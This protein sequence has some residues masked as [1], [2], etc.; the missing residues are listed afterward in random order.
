MGVWYVA[1]RE[2]IQLLRDRR[3]ILVFVSVPVVLVLLFG[4][5]LSFDVRH[6]STVVLDEDRTP[7]S[8]LL[9]ERF[10]QTGRFDLVGYVSSERELRRTLDYGRA[11]VG[12]RIPPRF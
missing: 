1:R 6:L 10:V 5:A 9:V 2:M 4:Y 7:A 3:T 11:Q 12:V 8:R